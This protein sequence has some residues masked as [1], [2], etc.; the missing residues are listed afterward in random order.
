MEVVV[1]GG[2]AVLLRRPAAELGAQGAAEMVDLTQDRIKAQK[3]CY[4]TS[5]RPKPSCLSDTMQI[6]CIQFMLQP[7]LQ[8]NST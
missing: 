7:L 4:K 1:V 3:M 2:G 8:I 6:Q 5:A